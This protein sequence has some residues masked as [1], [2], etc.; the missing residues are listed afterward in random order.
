MGVY[1]KE[2]GDWAEA[3]ELYDRARQLFEKT[4]DRAFES[5]A[6]FNTAEILSDQGHAEEAT[7]LLRDVIR[8]WRAAGAETDVAEAWR[9]LARLEA[10]RGDFDSATA[11]AERGA[12]SPGGPQPAR[13]GPDHRLSDGRDARPGRD[14]PGEALELAIELQTRA[15]TVEGGSSLIPSLQRIEGWA[16]LQQGRTAEASDQ[17]V[18]ALKL[19]RESCATTTRWPSRCA[20]S[21]PSP[22]ATGAD[23]AVSG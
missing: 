17:F 18:A 12:C 15:K 21:P 13:R 3:R 9:E 5:L 8:H 6:M 23:A 11:A 22:E 10:R 19:A 20:D 7:R 14:G 16:F 4:G 2:L 1:A